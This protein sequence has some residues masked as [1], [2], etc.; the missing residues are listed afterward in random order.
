[1]VGAPTGDGLFDLL[2][3]E[4]FLE[5]AV[6]EGGEFRVRGKPEADVLVFCELRAAGEDGCR[7]K[8]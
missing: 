2:A 7:E 8:P 1:M 3:G 5:C 6:D 4:V